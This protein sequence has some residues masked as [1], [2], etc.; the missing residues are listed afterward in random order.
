MDD[1]EEPNGRS[2]ETARFTRKRKRMTLSRG[3]CSSCRA[4]AW[5]TGNRALAY[6]R[7][8]AA[9]VVGAAALG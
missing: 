3:A 9:T 5:R 4:G 7:K 8:Q 2:S 6:R 1:G